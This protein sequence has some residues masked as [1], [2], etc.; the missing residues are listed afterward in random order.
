MITLNINGLKSLIEK[1]KLIDAFRTKNEDIIS[2][3]YISPNGK[4]RIDRIYTPEVNKNQIQKCMLLNFPYSDH[5]V[6]LLELKDS[7]LESLNRKNIWKLNTSILED[8]EFQEE[9]K[10]FI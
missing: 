10:L 4:S 9:I 3:I 8:P 1:L 5:N 6:V 7:N 2:F